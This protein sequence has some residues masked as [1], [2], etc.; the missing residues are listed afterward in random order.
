[1]LGLLFNDS[2]WGRPP[3]TNRSAIKA[4]AT[5][6]IYETHRAGLS[7]P[8]WERETGFQLSR[9]EGLKRWAGT[10]KPAQ[11]NQP[12]AF[13]PPDENRLCTA[14]GSFPAQWPTCPGTRLRLCPPRENWCRHYIATVLPNGVQFWVQE[15]RRFVV[16]RESQRE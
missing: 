3:G 10:P 8:S 7:G 1:M 2:K 9:P 12:T 6:V 4:A 15:R 11:P 16:V 14:S 13:V 5:A